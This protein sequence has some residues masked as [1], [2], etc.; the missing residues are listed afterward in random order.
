MGFYHEEEA[1][2]GRLFNRDVAAML[3]RYCLAYKK[4]LVVSLL[5]VAIISAA[6]L[7]GP[8]LAKTIIDKMIV[9]QGLVAIVGEAG[10]N[11][12][13]NRFLEK[14]ISR[15]VL[16]SAGAYFVMQSELSYFS[17]SDIER[18]TRQG[19]F[20]PEK[21]TLIE[22]PPAPLVEQALLAKLNKLAADGSVKK[23]PSGFYCLS[24]SGMQ[25]FT[26]SELLALRAHD[27]RRIGLF[28]VLIIGVFTVQ[29]VASYWQNITMTRLSQNAMRDLRRDLFAHIVSLRLVFFDTNPIGKLVNRVTNDI[30]VLNELFSSVLIAL[31]QDLLILTGIVVIM[32][33]A[34]VT[35]ALTVAATFPIL[36]GITIAFRLQ[37]RAAYRNIRTRISALNAFLSE[38]ISG[39]RIVQIFVHE[40]KQVRS[41]ASVNK[42]VYDANLK[43][44]YVYGIFR[45]LIEMFRWFAIAGVM[46]IGAGLIVND[47]LSYGMV[48][49]FL[50]YIGTFFEPLGDLAEK[51][52]TMQSATAAGEKI[53]LV[54]NAPVVKE[55]AGEAMTGAPVMPVAPG[56]LPVA[57]TKTAET[58]G[59]RAG[60][61]RFDDIWFAYR[62]TEWVLQGVSF[63]IPEG[64][65]LAIVG[66]TGSGKTTIANLLLRLYPVE[67]GVISIGGTPV[68]GIPY[69]VLRRRVVMVMQDVFLFSRTVADNITLSAPFDPKAFDD[70][71]RI[72]H[73]D[74]LLRSLPK[75]AAEPVMERGATFSAGE[76]QLLALARALYFDPAVL[77]LDE[78][79]SNIDTET[80][81]LIQDA[82]AHLIKGRTSLIIAH[83]LSTIRSADEIIVLDK[84]RIAE[85]GNHRSLLA[86]KGIY[87]KL[88]SLQF[89]GV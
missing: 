88:Y 59:Q 78:A 71:C 87:H 18:L 85:R 57:F 9:K 42:S 21:Y 20:M 46:C 60:E 69:R 32:F 70:A 54:F 45:P 62:P 63:S 3:L 51:F 76:R 6:T 14:K 17:K 37:A 36:A 25:Q 38:T 29:F 86:H 44:V 28:V 26:N 66:E 68:E 55:T 39:I 23:F 31:F 43:Q 49:M 7:S 56:Q 67:K 30:E 33:S 75:G 4:H 24:A 11:K 12:I 80:E 15:G 84:G 72:S 16:L 65:T 8:I 47:R 73:S 64:K 40:M 48:V 13:Q 89:E 83:R 52:D 2:N 77:V 22:A 81:R 53:M 10:N 1:I 61:V 19:V 34:N 5:M 27:L 82:I 79:T 50:S 74:R 41:F 35:L 58:A